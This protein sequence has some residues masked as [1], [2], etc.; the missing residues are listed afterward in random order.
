MNRLVS[1]SD[2]KVNSISLDSSGRLSVIFSEVIEG[3]YGGI[4]LQSAIENYEL[5]EDIQ[6]TIPDDITGDFEDFIKRIQGFYK[7]REEFFKA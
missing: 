7:S 1:N 5:N 6:D 3:I 2:I 4:V